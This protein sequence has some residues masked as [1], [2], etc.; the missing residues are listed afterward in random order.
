[1]IDKKDIEIKNGYIHYKGV[2]LNLP[3]ESLEEYQFQTGENPANLIINLY[4]NS[5]QVRREY[6]LK[7]VLNDRT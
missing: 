6:K 5:L 3:P 1:M 4:K 7:Q 2:D